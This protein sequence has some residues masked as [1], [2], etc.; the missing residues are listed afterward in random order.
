[1]HPSFDI[2]KGNDGVNGFSWGAT[3]N[4]LKWKAKQELLVVVEIYYME[5]V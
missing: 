4:G 2:M 1:M 5:K 3:E